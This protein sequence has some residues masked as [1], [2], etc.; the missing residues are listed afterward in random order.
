M[1][2]SLEE[3]TQKGEPYTAL[4][5]CPCGTGK[6]TAIGVI[7]E[8]S[9]GRTLV[10]D[11]DRTITKTLAKREVVKDLSKITV[12]Q[13]DN[14]HTWS[15]WEN[16]LKELAD[17]KKSGQ[18]EF[19]NIAVDNI[20]ELERCILSDLG[21]QGKNKGVPAQADY[22]YMQFKLVNSL[23]FMKSLGVNVIWTA[24]ETVEQFTNPDG[25]TYSRLYPKCNAKIVDNICGL[26]DV[27]GKI[28]AK[29]DGTRGIILEAT[30]NIYAKNQIDNR[31]GC[32]VEEF[33]NFQ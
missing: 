25:S 2:Q 13:I 22:Q 10:L 17:L 31:K 1:Y 32:L 14:I 16:A 6:S 29:Q 23:R 18:L 33:I 24:W 3:L 8:K 30:Q 12:R 4:L 15:D 11:I 9:K 5:Y 26:C 19:E 7:A 27:V 20:S 21:A 28:L